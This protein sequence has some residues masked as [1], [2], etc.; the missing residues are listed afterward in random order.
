MKTF[1]A[2]VDAIGGVTIHSTESMHIAFSPAK[3][4][5]PPIEIN[6]TP[7]DQHLDGRT[8]LA[9]VRNRTDSSDGRRML[10]QRCM[11]RD[12]ASELDAG[13]LLTRFSAILRAIANSTTTTMPLE[14]LPEVIRAIGTLDTGDIATAA[15]G[16]PGYTRGTNYMGLPI[17]DAAASQARVAEIIAGFYAPDTGTTGE[18]V[19]DECG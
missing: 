16:Y 6:I 17:I 18:P 10:R 13:T 7:G 8:A 14:L 5:E 11:L 15:I 19:E 1:E 9:Y 4:G 3:P 12:L 2:V